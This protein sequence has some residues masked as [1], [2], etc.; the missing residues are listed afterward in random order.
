MGAITLF[1]I[2]FIQTGVFGRERGRRGEGRGGGETKSKDQKL[3]WLICIGTL[4]GLGLFW[5]NNTKYQKNIIP[6]Q[7]HLC[8]QSTSAY[9]VLVGQWM[10]N[11]ASGRGTSA[12]VIGWVN[13]PSRVRLKLFS[14]SSKHGLPKQHG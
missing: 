11:L 8:P 13:N 6:F 12:K 3:G 9:C 4:S 1:L 5:P 10:V 2:N 7:T 14:T